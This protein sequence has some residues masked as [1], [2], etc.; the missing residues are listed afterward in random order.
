MTNS[1][2]ISQNNIKVR[3]L[4]LRLGVYILYLASCIF[5]M[6]FFDKYNDEI[7]YR[8][9]YPSLETIEGIDN[10]SLYDTSIFLLCFYGLSLIGYPIIGIIKDQNYEDI[11]KYRCFVIIM[12]LFLFQ[13][14]LSNSWKISMIYYLVI[15]L[16]ETMTISIANMTFTNLV[17]IYIFSAMLVVNTAFGKRSLN[18][19]KNCVF[20]K[21]KFETNNDENEANNDENETNNNETNNN[22]T[23]NNIKKC[24][25]KIG[26]SKYLIVLILLGITIPHELIAMIISLIFSF[27]YRY[28]NNI[29]YNEKLVPFQVGI[30]GI[31]F[32]ILIVGVPIVW[33]IVQCCCNVCYCQCDSCFGHSH[34]CYDF[35]KKLKCDKNN[36][37]CGS[38]K[39]YDF[40]LPNY[41]LLKYIIFIFLVIYV[42]WRTCVV[43]Y[44]YPILEIYDDTYF[45]YNSV[46]FLLSSLV[47]SSAL[48]LISL[49]MILYDQCISTCSNNDSDEETNAN[50]N[51]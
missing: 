17:W 21:S 1:E 30:A 18:A 20:F 13:F 48:Y 43:Y 38:K 28:S 23:N 9:D 51:V 16:N 42:S 32:P 5:D 25:S 39:I 11:I 2:I 26:S 29:L 41:C 3:N 50:D 34:P 44:I 24:C 49:I 45:K 7:N 47:I 46:L 19:C 14:L 22:E 6:V 31:L 36:H 4:F 8:S 35:H 37:C 40:F 12:T 27:E 15:E 33:V 10:K